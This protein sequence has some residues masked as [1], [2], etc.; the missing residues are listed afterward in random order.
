MKC[1]QFVS[2]R[3]DCCLAATTIQLKLAIVREVGVLVLGKCTQIDLVTY[4]LGNRR[5]T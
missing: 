3:V 4:E 1:R 5:G 2:L